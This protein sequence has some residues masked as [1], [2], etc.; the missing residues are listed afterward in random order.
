MNAQM[1]SLRDQSGIAELRALL[2]QHERDLN[3]LT[4]EKNIQYTK[5]KHS[6]KLL[7]SMQLEHD[8]HEE[9]VIEEKKHHQKLVIEMEQKQ[10]EME[11]KM[12]EEI[13]KYKLVK[14]D[15][16]KSRRFREK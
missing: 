12:Q 6:V 8:K 9:E 5:M 13:Q 7:E 2:Q 4:E 14:V 16:T 1:E 10:Q 11:S 3:S 15:R